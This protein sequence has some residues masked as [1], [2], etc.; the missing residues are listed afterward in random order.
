M[1]STSHAS[2]PRSF[3]AP[4]EHAEA[5]TRLALEIAAEHARRLRHPDPPPL[6]EAARGRL[7]VLGSGIQTVGFTLGDREVIERADRVFFCVADPA[8][9]VWLKRLRPDAYD[10][11]VL[12]DD[13][14]PRYATY[15]QMAEAMLHGVRRGEHVVCVFYGHP[16]VFVLSTH[17]AIAIAR[18]E[19]HAA[20]MRAA[21]SALDCLCA[22][23][24]IDPSNPGL[25]THEATDLLVRR[26]VP[27]TTLHVVLWQ[28]GLIGELG[29]RR[30]GF[31]NRNF[32]TFVEYLQGHYGAAYPVVHYIASRYPTVPP[33]IER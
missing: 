3:P 17:R 5:W 22:D 6:A 2:V 1:V 20:E 10:L 14:K 33:L 9:I 12:Y 30:K 7:T 26:R 29:F 19:G 25:Q 16:G 21:V 11:Y 27:D 28:V 23:L 4:E 8:T 13:A 32:S 15:M 31:L 24:G 18:R